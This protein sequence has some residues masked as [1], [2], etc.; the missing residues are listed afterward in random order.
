MIKKLI[1]HIFFSC[2][3]ATELVEK[4]QFVKLSLLE[5]VRFKGHM[6]ICSACRSYEKQSALMEK[7]FHRINNSSIPEQEIPKMN[8]TAKTRILEILKEES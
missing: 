2:K 5:K 8:D 3:H 6:L 4:K 1:G 7:M